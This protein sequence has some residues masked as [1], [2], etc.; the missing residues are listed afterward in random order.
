MNRHEMIDRI[1]KE[2][3]TTNIEAGEY[4]YVQE[5]GSKEKLEKAVGHAVKHF[6]LDIRFENNSVA[7][8]IETKQ[9]FT[10]ADEKQLAEYVEEERALHKGIKIIAILANTNN[11]KIKVWRYFVDDSHLLKEETVLDTMEHYVKLFDTARQNDKERVMKNTYDLNELLHKKD[12]DEK[13]RSQFV[14]TTLLYIKDM[15]KKTGATRIDDALKDKLDDVW[16]M[17]SA[18]EIRAGIK[19][20]LD[21]LLDNSENK[22]KKIELLQKNVLNDQKVKKLKIKDW[23]E[24][25]DTILMDI[26]RYID[27]DSSEGQD[28]L[29]LFFIAFNKYTGKAD[30]NQAFTPD[31]I[32]EF[33]CRITDVDRTKVVLDGTCGSGSFLVQAMV[34]EIADCRRDKTEKE[35]EELIRQVKEKH[36]FGIEVEEKAYGLSTTN[37]LI[38]GDG[39]SN[40]KFGSIFD[41]KKFIME[42]DPDIILMNPPYNAKPI[43]IPAAY[44]TTWTAKAKDGKEDPTKGFV[45]VHFISDVIK[46]LND[47]KEKSGKP[48][49]QVKLAVLLPVAAAIGTSD[50]IE[51]EK[52]AMLENNTLEAVFTLPNEIFYPGASA[53]ACCML[54]TLGKPHS[55]EKETFFGYCKDDGFKKKKNLGRVEQFNVDNESLWK[56]IEK[57]WLYLFRNHKAEPGKSATVVVNGESEWLCEAYM[58]TDYSRLSETDFQ[59]TLNNYLAYQIKEGK[60][61]ES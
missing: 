11:D 22:T 33:M 27:A 23:I 37:M 55:E 59:T 10:K 47:L 6:K 30:K 58:K 61:Y 32:T 2:Y 5:A 31:H 53:C 3:L 36:I 24:I 46:E 43:G 54:F 34:K 45:F 51:K 50:I 15:V 57:E 7:V 9:S 40:I 18:E 39:N 38:H 56:K 41:S 29:N 16:K 21:N 49:K 35:A 19:N 44:K 26:Y 52:I 8:L 25:L 4:S 42:A 12:I 17:M 20:T 1:G 13:L 28:I 14:G 60:V 48:T